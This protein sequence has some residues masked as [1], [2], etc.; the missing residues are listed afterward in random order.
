MR[1][2]FI[3][4]LVVAATPLLLA[5]EYEIGAAGGYGIYR[6]ASVDTANGN[7]TAGV[8]NRFAVGAVGCQDM[9]EHISGELRYLYQDGD[10]FV[11]S[12]GVRGNVQGQSHAIDY[13][14]LFHV[15]KREARLRPYFE[16][17]LGAK[18]YR[19]TGPAPA[20]QPLPNIVTLA[21]TS[22]WRILG[23]FG[24]GIKYRVHKRL[25]LRVDFLDY[26]TPFP[27]SL[28]VPAAGGTGRGILHQ[29][30]PLAGIGYSFDPHWI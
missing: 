25:V 1:Y 20:V 13:A 10:P 8:R 18:Y 28:F 30:T 4:A 27:G 21:N 24:G 6:N 23:V 16:A 2:A 7:A 19:V 15:K 26:V 3:L 22:Q 29:L 5:Q 9:Y 14:L 12:G 17:G 11:S